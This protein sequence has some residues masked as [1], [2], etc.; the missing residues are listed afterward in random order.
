MIRK[1]AAEFLGTAI[2]ASIH[3]RN[4]GD[5]FLAVGVGA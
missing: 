5:R 4:L 1:F 2:L 3:R